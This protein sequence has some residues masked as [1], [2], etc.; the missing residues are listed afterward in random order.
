MQVKLIVKNLINSSDVLNSGLLDCLFKVKFR[1]QIMSIVG[2]VDI[3]VR[4][5]TS[6]FLRFDF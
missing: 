3:L 2:F 6:S 5:N 4:L 1:F